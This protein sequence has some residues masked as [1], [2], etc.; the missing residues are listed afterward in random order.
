M[1]LSMIPVARQAMGMGA[2]GPP[3]LFKLPKSRKRLI[4]NFLPFDL[5][6]NPHGGGGGGDFDASEPLPTHQNDFFAE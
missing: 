1:L 6:L 2:R 3:R 4:G 5:A